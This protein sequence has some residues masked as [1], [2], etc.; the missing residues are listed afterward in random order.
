MI[1]SHKHEFIFIAAGKTGTYSIENELANYNDSRHI[2]V[3]DSEYGKIGNFIKDEICGLYD[4]RKKIRVNISGPAT[5][6]LDDFLNLK[7]MTYVWGG[8]KHVPP[9]LIK[10]TVNIDEFFKFA[11]VRNP[12]DWVKCQ[13]FH[14][15]PEEEKEVLTEN[16]IFSVRRFLADYTRGIQT[17]T[18]YQYAFLSSTDDG[19]GPLLVDFVGK[20]ERLQKDLD[21]ACDKIGI[22]RCILPHRNKGI[23]SGR[24]KHYSQFYT[25]KTR[26][27]VRKLYKKD[28]E[29]F[30]YEFEDKR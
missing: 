12:W 19:K 24:K 15:F 14:C 26:D 25:D 4:P 18:K 30:E 16:D 27:L 2:N 20:F 8:T 17:D 23:D 1:I 13:F 3:I 6:P 29:Y 28:I 10:G 7:E 22:P 9:L 5:L 11:F 21:I